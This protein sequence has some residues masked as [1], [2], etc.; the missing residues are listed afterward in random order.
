M[1]SERPVDK[2]KKKWSKKYLSVMDIL[3]QAVHLSTIHMFI[4]TIPDVFAE[5]SVEK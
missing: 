4:C 1:C 5:W 3:L 2:A